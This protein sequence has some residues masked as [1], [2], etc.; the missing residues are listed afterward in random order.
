MGTQ[1]GTGL[2]LHLPIERRAGAGQGTPEPV[3]A[4]CAHTRPHRNPAAGDHSSTYGLRE[5]DVFGCLVIL[6]LAHFT[7]P[8]ILQVYLCSSLPGFLPFLRLIYS[9]LCTNATFLFHSSMDGLLSCFH[10]LAAECDAAVHMGVCRGLPEP[11]LSSFGWV[12]RR[13]MAR[14]I[15]R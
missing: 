5:V 6:R 15:M 14:W 7:G 3:G 2:M 12:P 9:P 4:H 13:G 8:A 11:A 10:L 1:G